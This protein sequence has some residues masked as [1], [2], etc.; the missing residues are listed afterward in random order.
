MMSINGMI[1]MRARLCGTGEEILISVKS[2]TRPPVKVKV[3]G[4]VTF[5]AVPGLNFHRRKPV[6]AA[7]SS[8]GL[9]V[10]FCT[11]TSVTR[12]LVSQRG[13]PSLRCP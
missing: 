5:G 3:M 10:L 9:P 12:R 6:T 8:T 1:S 4:A 13:K 7:L 2:S 11:V